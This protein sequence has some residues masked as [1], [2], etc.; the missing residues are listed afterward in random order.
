MFLHAEHVLRKHFC[1]LSLHKH[2]TF[3]GLKNVLRML[4]PAETGGDEASYRPHPRVH[5]GWSA[6]TGKPLPSFR[7]GLVGRAKHPR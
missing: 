3:K 6:E 1:M 4:G 2:T 5:G 7:R